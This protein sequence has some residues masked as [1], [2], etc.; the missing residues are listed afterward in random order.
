M[1]GDRQSWESQLQAGVGGTVRLL[2]RL[3]T[4]LSGKANQVLDRI[5][6]PGDA[7]DLAYQEELEQTARVHDAVGSVAGCCSRLSAL[8]VK[9][10]SAGSSLEQLAR[11]SI[12]AGNRELA[13]EAL[14]RRHVIDAGRL[15]LV[16]EAERLADEER[17][18]AAA[19][20]VLEA[21]VSET[22]AK[23]EA[24]KQIFKAS[25]D[26]SELER[27]VAEIRAQTDG[28]RLAVHRAGEM[29]RQVTGRATAIDSLL[30]SGALEDLEVTP[31][32]LAA[33]IA[34]ARGQ[35]AVDEE[36]SG[37]R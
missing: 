17:H 21:K 14:A 15:S 3:A 9:L 28:V 26:R 6:D 19:A 12:R 18:L 8:N 16:A 33:E 24:L 27:E 22:G 7:V 34:A 35:E 37:L 10:S 31:P 1:P 32:A 11:R 2:K 13:R 30:E 36:M 5:D 4:N 25:G 20:L 23:K 29:V